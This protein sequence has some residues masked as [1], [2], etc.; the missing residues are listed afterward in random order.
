MCTSRGRM[1]APLRCRRPARLSLWRPWRRRI[2]SERVGSDPG[3]WGGRSDMVRS[4][5]IWRERKRGRVIGGRGGGGGEGMRRRRWWPKTFL[6]S[7]VVGTESGWLDARWVIYIRWIM[8]ERLIAPLFLLTA[9][10]RLSSFPHYPFI[11]FN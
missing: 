4:G 10:I 3:E 9:I 5:G 6:I 7:Y 8:D 2:G 1:I 11:S